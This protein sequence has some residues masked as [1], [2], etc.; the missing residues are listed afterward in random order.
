MIL[1]EIF[2]L[3]WV[4][5]LENKFK[6]M[7]TSLGI[8]VGAATIVLVIAIGRGGQMDVADQFKNLN[9]GT[10][11]IKVGSSGGGSTMAVMMMP[12]MSAGG[13]GN[14]GNMGTPTL[15]K[16]VQLDEEDVEDISL[17]VPDIS[18]I[19]ISASAQSTVMGG[20]LEEEITATIAA[21]KPE[22]M[23][24]S[25]LD[26]AI[27]DFISEVNDTNVEK[28]AVIGYDL[29]IDVF[30]SLMEAFDNIIV[31]DGRNYTVAGVLSP[32][33]SVSSGISPDSAV[34]LPYSTGLKYVIGRNP[35]PIITAVADDVKAV[36]DIISN[37]SSV[38]N[39][40]YPGVD[41]AVTDAGS[42][43]E[44]ASKSANTLAMLLISVASIVFI[45]GGIGIMNVLFVSVKERTKEIGI[46][47]ALGCSKQDI[48][49]EFLL[50]SNIISCFG[51]VVGV[52]VSFA[53]L[54]ILSR[55]GMRVENSMLGVVMALVF[56]IATGTIFGIY[57]A[58]KAA[59]LVPIEALNE[60]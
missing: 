40:T 34:F 8:I 25:N 2:N 10:V 44:A 19:T 12:A 27:G 51:G 17:F 20:D 7:L 11:E 28:V 23:E 49:L 15:F 47:K 50:E 4:N 57:P 58:M 13:G 43:M 32:M 48:L 39:Q 45:V 36:P 1:S 30:G 31:I 52:A 55:F 37:V 21:V 33:G 3:V 18:D 14:R 60:E 29:A 38:L 59:A 24:M 46:L 6:V 54:P 41:F 16:N 42:K 5:I 26:L 22:F 35:K 9:A 53:L 56:A